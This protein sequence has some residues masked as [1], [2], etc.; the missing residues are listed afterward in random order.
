MP[1]SEDTSTIE[2]SAS[3]SAM[4]ASAT[5]GSEMSPTAARAEPPASVIWVTVSWALSAMSATTTV[6]P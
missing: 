6:A 3:A 5:A 4:S 2:P 1:A